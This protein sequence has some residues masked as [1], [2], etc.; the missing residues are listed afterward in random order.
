MICKQQTQTRPSCISGTYEQATLG[1]VCVCSMVV[2]SLRAPGG[3]QA[4]GLLVFL[5]SSY[6]TP[7]RTRLFLSD[8]LSHSLK[9]VY[10]RRHGLCSVS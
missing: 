9:H 2:Q 6:A 3:F 7:S 10:Y 1:P 8:T 5:W 4:N